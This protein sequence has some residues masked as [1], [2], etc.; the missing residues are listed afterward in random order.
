[1]TVRSTATL[2]A[3]LRAT[4]LAAT[5][6]SAATLARAQER[7]GG[8][9]VAAATVAAAHPRGGDSLRRAVNA[10]SSRAGE[11]RGH[12]FDAGI[13]LPLPATSLRIDGSGGSHTAISSL[14]GGFAFPRVAAGRYTLVV[15]RPSYRP[16]HLGIVVPEGSTL[17]LDVQLT[18]LPV[19][20]RPV[21]VRVE[22][23]SAS[24]REGELPAASLADSRRIAR[25]LDYLASPASAVSALLGIT[26]GRRPTD[27][28]NPRNGR[29]LFIWGA[30]D[31]GARVTF[32]GIPL[33]APLHLGGLLP[34][35]DEDLMAPASMW[36]AGAPSRADGGTDYILDLKTRD[37]GPDSLRLWATMDMLTARAGGEVPIGARGSVLAGV[38]R[39]NDGTVGRW[40]GAKPGY[41]YDDA[42]LRVKLS[43]AIGQTLLTTL[44]A[45]NEGLDIPRDQGRDRARWGNR[46]AALQW[47]RAGASG[48]TMVR[49]SVS[50]ASIELP[51][52]T[53]TDG[54]L[55]ADALR[56]SVLAEQRWSAERWESSIGVEGERLLVQRAVAGDSLG[57]PI[58]GANENLPCS[59]TTTC[60]NAAPDARVAGTTTALYLDHQRVL[61]SWLRLGAGLRTTV[62]PDVAGGRTP[63]LLPRLSLD[64]M[65][66]SGTTLRISAGRYSRLATIIDRGPGTPNIAQPAAVANASDPVALIA[67]AAA[68]Q[69]ELGAT[70]RWRHSVFGVSAYW[71]RASA[72]PLGSASTRH[73]GIDAMW[74]YARSTTTVTASYTRIVRH[75]ALTP[76]SVGVDTRS[77]QLEQL[78]SLRATT[79]RGRVDATMSASYAHGLSFASVVLERPAV[80]VTGASADLPTRFENTIPAQTAYLRVDA[81]LS[82]RLC[83]DGAA[84]RMMVSPYARVL[85]ALDRR[86]AIFYYGDATSRR[87]NRLAGFPALL[88]VG[89]RLDFG[90][91]RSE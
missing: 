38:R 23:D 34:V 50:S 35:V 66:A 62:A 1:M 44:L 69:M 33:G 78:A 79:R 27:P 36:T 57:T 71:Q 4:V 58:P 55:R 15:A 48:R 88:S 3:T 19:S 82:A 24:A 6:A 70:Q 26:P 84:C 46:A 22:S 12:V 51:L 40:A 5:F 80:S 64:A 60:I 59:Q 77:V 68:M 17:V 18:R 85:N 41:A 7:T 37:P 53:L 63:L 25:G 87:P 49:G 9:G 30:R 52:L 14:D 76:D 42:L 81:M 28:G 21:V 32:D 74:E 8:A 16:A 75:F 67:R 56:T 86:D 11:V 54:H 72:I 91:G 39:V 29:T 13:A 65:P 10:D 20:L 73:R 2:R 61:A 89:A 45:T 47:D 83:A 31:A 90:H 43:P